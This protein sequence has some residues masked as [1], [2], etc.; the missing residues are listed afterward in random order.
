MSGIPM[1][2]SPGTVDQWPKNVSVAPDVRRHVDDPR[3]RRPPHRLLV[4]MGAQPAGVAGLAAR[5]PR[6]DGR[7]RRASASAAARSSS[8]TRAAPAPPTAPTSGCRSRPAPT[9][10]SCSRSCHVLFA[11]D[12]VDLGTVADLVDGVDERARR[13]SPTG[14]PSAVAAIDRHPRRDASAASPTSSPSAERGVVYGRIGLCNQEF[15][16]LA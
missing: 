4:V 15:G 10:R 6:R 9:P 7:D 1:I 5:V 3:A 8:S 14:R 16:T 13:S 2:Y 11:E 12:L